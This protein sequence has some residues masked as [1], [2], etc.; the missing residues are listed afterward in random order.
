MTLS[1]PQQLVMTATPIPRTVAMTIFGDLETSTLREI[2]AG[3]A[4]IT[5]YL[6]PADHPSWIRR[7]WELVREEVAT[8]GRVYVVCP[9]ISD[10]EDEAQRTA[11]ANDGDTTRPLAA[12]TDVAARLREAPQLRS[13][14][15]RVG[16]ERRA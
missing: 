13:E 2:P 14:E 9:R 8:G 1:T 6:C 10:A 4:G 7:T 3:R 16:Q 5:T 12:V 15:R 11:T